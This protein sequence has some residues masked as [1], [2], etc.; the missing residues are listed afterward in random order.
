M[1]GVAQRT[2]RIGMGVPRFRKNAAHLDEFVGH[3]PVD[4]Q[5]DRHACGAQLVAVHHRF[6]DQRI[7][8]GQSQPDG[9][10]IV[11]LRRQERRKAPVFAVSRAAQ[12]MVEKPADVGLLQH[13]ALREP[14]VRRRVLMGRAAGVKQQ[15]QGQL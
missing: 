6:I 12:V 7:T 3:A 9:R 13:E 14:A 1:K 4:F 8:L 5:L 15:L 11:H 2:G 10:H